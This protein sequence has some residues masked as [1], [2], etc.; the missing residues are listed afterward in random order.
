MT[1]LCGI[2]LAPRL[3]SWPSTAYES[4]YS[5]T[6]KLQLVPEYSNRYQSYHKKLKAASGKSSLI[7]TCCN[8]NVWKCAFWFGS[9][10]LFSCPLWFAWSSAA[11]PQVSHTASNST[12]PYAGRPRPFPTKTRK[13]SLQNDSQVV[14]V[15]NN[16]TFS[17]SWFSNFKSCKFTPRL[18]MTMARSTALEMP[19][20]SHPACPKWGKA[21]PETPLLL[22]PRLSTSQWMIGWVRECAK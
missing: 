1:H 6:D 11:W 3:I 20:S 19:S 8:K 4:F 12:S 5:L 22:G 14:Q 18:P 16:M 15:S 10:F 17:N 7:A 2:N 21:S 13:E 9:S